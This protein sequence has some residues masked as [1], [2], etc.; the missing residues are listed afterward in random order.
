MPKKTPAQMEEERLR[1]LTFHQ[2][3]ISQNPAYRREFIEAFRNYLVKKYPGHAP[4]PFMDDREERISFTQSWCPEAFDL[5]LKW[6]LQVPWDP[7]DVEPPHPG[8]MP[9]GRIVNCQVN[10]LASEQ[11]RE[12]RIELSKPRIEEVGERYFNFRVLERDLDLVVRREKSKRLLE[13]PECRYLLLEI[14]LHNPKKEIRHWLNRVVDLHW[15]RADVRPS[16][17]VRG[18]ELDD[19]IL[20]VQSLEMAGKSPEEITRELYPETIGKSLSADA[21]AKSRYEKVRRAS[22]KWKRLINSK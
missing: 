17:K 14:D 19:F 1:K 12:G 10:P 5:T 7:D 8:L 9:P 4:E 11:I 18:P 22:K 13:S 6:K 16:L 15:K 3:S 20:K 2:K 21:Q